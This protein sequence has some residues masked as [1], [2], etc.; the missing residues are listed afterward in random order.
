MTKTGRNLMLN[1]AREGDQIFGDFVP[2]SGTASRLIAGAS[3]ISPSLIARLILPTFAAQ[4]LYGGSRALTRGL[5]NVPSVAASGGGRVASGLLGESAF[6]MP[7]NQMQNLM[8]Y[9]MQQ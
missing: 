1:T 9:R 7:Q 3:A 2:D 4:G 8:N 5:I 6:N